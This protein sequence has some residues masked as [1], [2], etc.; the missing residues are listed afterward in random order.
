MIICSLHREINKYRE[1]NS[2]GRT[3]AVEL[4]YCRIG[5]PFEETAVAVARSNEPL[6][7]FRIA[8]FYYSPVLCIVI[9]FSLCFA[10]I[11]V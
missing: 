9:H 8:Q 10:C 5:M 6:S 3:K 2:S 11:C 4:Y 7:R 1:K